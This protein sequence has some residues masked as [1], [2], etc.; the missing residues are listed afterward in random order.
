MKPVLTVIPGGKE[1]P[2]AKMNTKFAVV[3]VGG[4]MRIVW[5]EP[6]AVFDDVE[7]VVYA[8]KTNFM[9]LRENER[10]PVKD[11]FGGTKQVGIGKW[12]L[13]QPDR[14]QYDR[15]VFDPGLKDPKAF[16]LWRGFSVEPAKG[17]C[18]RYLA[19]LFENVCRGNGEHFNYLLNWMARAVQSPELQGEVAV[20]MRGREGTGKGVA[21]SQFGKLFG[22]HY[23][24]ISQPDHLTGHFNAHLQSVSVLFADEAFFAGDRRHEGVLKALITEPTLMVEIKGVD[25]FQVRNSLHVMMSS[26]SQWVVP[27]G[28]EARRFFCL[29]VSDGSMQ[30][31][32]YFAAIVEEMDNGGRAALLR[33]LQER[34]ITRFNVRKVPRTSMLEDQ[35]A[36][37][38]RGIDA[39]VY[40]L[41]DRGE[42]PFSHPLYPNIAITNGESQGE[43]F[44]CAVRTMISDQSLRLMA[45]SVIKQLLRDNYDCQ[46]WKSNS[47]N[48]IK[49]PPLA[50]LRARFPLQAHGEDGAEWTTPPQ[51]GE[52]D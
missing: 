19:H 36:H 35:Q 33:V 29:D 43:G 15:V 41:V 1:D 20:V 17:K 6:S 4:K 40:E 22:Q 52:D 28:A 50:A 47:K 2:L 38:R 11:E 42:L 46:H 13:S 8:D 30:N 45:P 21:I 25:A 31:S 12:W 49:F 39:L 16:N 37:S 14:K 51:F 5:F 3:Q 10:V 48:G 27:A 26:N 7:T 44:I 23:L 9:A 24:H 34:D 32:D 18:K